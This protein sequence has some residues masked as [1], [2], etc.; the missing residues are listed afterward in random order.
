MSEEIRCPG[1]HT[2]RQDKPR[3]GVGYARRY[4]CGTTVNDDN[5]ALRQ[6]RFCTEKELRSR[7][8]LSE[9]ATDLFIRQLAQARARIAELVEIIE[10]MYDCGTRTGVEELYAEY[11]KE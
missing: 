11:Q 7:L 6:G 4:A 10:A 5:E 8:A 9:Q 2:V 1:C 3:E